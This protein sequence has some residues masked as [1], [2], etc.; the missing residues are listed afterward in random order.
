MDLNSICSYEDEGRTPKSFQDSTWSNRTEI[1]LIKSTRNNFD[2]SLSRQGHQGVSKSQRQR[3]KSISSN[4]P[5]PK[6]GSSRDEGNCQR[7]GEDTGLEGID[8]ELDVTKCMVGR[9]NRGL[10]RAAL[11]RSSSVE[12]VQKNWTEQ[13]NSRRNTRYSTGTNP[14]FNE[15]STQLSESARR[16]TPSSKSCSNSQESVNL[17][18]INSGCILQASRDMVKADCQSNRS[19]FEIGTRRTREKRFSTGTCPNLSELNISEKTRG[20]VEPFFLPKIPGCVD[21]N[22]DNFAAPKHFPCISRPFKRAASA[23]H[24]E[25]TQLISVSASNT[26]LQTIVRRTSE[27]DSPPCL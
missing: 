13:H 21:K 18:T 16:C 6:I 14:K 17:E 20:S 24:S 22:V 3:K 15:L 27:P 9:N 25:K 12:R 10:Q 11:C 7:G 19:R 26:Q 2:A 8:K 23:K 4:T 1:S 5:T